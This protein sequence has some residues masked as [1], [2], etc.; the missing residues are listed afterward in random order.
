M[1][2]SSEAMILAVMKAILAIASRILN[3][4]GLQRGLG[5]VSRDR[6]ILLPESE[7]MFSKE[8]SI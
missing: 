3:N 1:I 5:D 6:F 8:I 4:S 2:I 7:I